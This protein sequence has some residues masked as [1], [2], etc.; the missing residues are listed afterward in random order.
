MTKRKKSF[1]HWRWWQ[2]GFQTP[3]VSRPQH[4]FPLERTGLRTAFWP[5][6]VACRRGSHPLITW[7]QQGHQSG[8]GSQSS[9]RCHYLQ[10]FFYSDYSTRRTNSS[11]RRERQKISRAGQQG[12]V[13]AGQ[14]SKPL[15]SF[16]SRT[17]KTPT[18]KKYVQGLYALFFLFFVHSLQ[19]TLLKKEQYT[20]YHECKDLRCT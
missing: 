8:T 19:S 5:G 15:V 9:C 2:K 12:R 18:F 7:G 3:V 1:L 6:G 13:C 11:F 17:K 4:Y 10:T 14:G 20:L 16:V